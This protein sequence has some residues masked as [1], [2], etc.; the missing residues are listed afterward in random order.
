MGITAHAL[1]HMED[2]LGFTG[3]KQEINLL[4]F[5]TD[6]SGYLFIEIL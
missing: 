2:M 6:A 5:I 4:V 3:N 1:T